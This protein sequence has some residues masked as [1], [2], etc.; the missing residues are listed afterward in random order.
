MIR[1]LYSLQK[2]HPDKYSTH[3]TPCTDVTCIWYHAQLLHVS[4]TMHS[5]YMY[6]IPCTVVV[7]CIWHH[8]QLLRVSG[9]M[10]SCYN[11][12]HYISY[13]VVYIPVAVFITDNLY[14]LFFKRFYLFLERGE[15]KEKEGERN[16][17]VWLPLMHPLLG[18]WLTTQACALIGNQTCNPL[19]CRPAL[20]PLSHTIQGLR[21]CF[22]CF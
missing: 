19:V 22:H 7:T 10:H 5:C 3:L 2:D 9:T 17:S 21:T 4:G 15:G 16:I 6:L 11:S 1:H 14:F 12:I 8:A 20:S 13:A 18:T